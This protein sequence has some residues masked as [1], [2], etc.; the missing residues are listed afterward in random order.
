MSDVIEHIE[1]EENRLVEQRG[2]TL[3]E[4]IQ[5]KRIVD[6]QTFRE[7]GAL[8][9]RAKEQRKMIAPRFDVPVASAYKAHKDA[10]KLR[11]DA[12]ATFDEAE[13]L[14][15]EKLANYI[16]THG[17]QMPETEGVSYVTAWKVDI[18]EEGQIPR[19]YLK[20]DEKKLAAVASRLKGQ[21]R[22]PGVRV[23]PVIEMRVTTDE[24]AP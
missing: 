2:R 12:L 14:A 5:H 6:D 22:I 8:L 11:E 9:R 10:C 17:G 1:H 23:S 19:E 4:Q 3:F 16:I 18:T 7:L 21:T 13:K 24:P 15:K 20:P